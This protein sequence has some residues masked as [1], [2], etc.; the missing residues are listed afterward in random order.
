ML[1]RMGI[2]CKVHPRRI[3]QQIAEFRGRW[4]RTFTQRKN[5]RSGPA[6]SIS[7]VAT[8]LQ[9]GLQAATV[10]NVQQPSA[11]MAH[12]I[13][14]TGPQAEAPGPR[15]EKYLTASIWFQPSFTEFGPPIGSPVFWEKAVENA[16]NSHEHLER[17][18]YAPP[19]SFP[20]LIPCR[21]GYDLVYGRHGI[22]SSHRARPSP[23]SHLNLYLSNEVVHR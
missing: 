20:A 16:Q 2:G 18:P 15:A 6:Q 12:P 23:P 9:R 1:S 11:A 17:M 21:K 7:V 5:S 8:E 19:P 14:P 4:K 10:S 3:L 22:R 13:R